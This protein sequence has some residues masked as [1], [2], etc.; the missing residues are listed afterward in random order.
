VDAL[1]FEPRGNAVFATATPRTPLV[2]PAIEPGWE[3]FLQVPPPSS[4][5]PQL[6]RLPL[7]FGSF[8]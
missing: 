7:S 8:Y 2:M 6:A 3:C 5:H 1:A 4:P